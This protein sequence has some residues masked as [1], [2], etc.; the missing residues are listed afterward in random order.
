VQVRIQSLTFQFSE[1]FHSGQ[2]IGSTE[3]EVLNRARVEAIRRVANEMVKTV[4][5]SFIDRV[6]TLEAINQLRYKIKILDTNFQFNP[7]HQKIDSQSQIEQ[8]I[9]L[10]AKEQAE[11]MFRQQ[12][13]DP[14]GELVEFINLIDQLKS[15]P[16][17]ESAARARVAK[18][19]TLSALALAD[20]L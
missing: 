15:L 4:L 20:L 14:E 10:Y 17:T 12:A 7:R 5:D 3:A 6:P 16:G 9:A 18:R 2:V 11:R 13:R 1:P 19:N 8:E